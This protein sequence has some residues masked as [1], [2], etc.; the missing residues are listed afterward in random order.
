WGGGDATRRRL[1]P[2]GEQLE[3][4]GRGER[5][6]ELVRRGD[7]DEAVGRGGDDLLA[8][9]RRAAALD[10]PAVRRDLV[11]AVDRDVETVERVERLDRQ[12]EPARRLLRPERRGDAADPQVPRRESRE[13]EPDRRAGAETDGHSVLD[14]LGRGLRRR[15]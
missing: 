11:G 13:E 2:E 10:E 15:T 14:E 9:V 7:D 4:H 6:D 8:R 1:E 5:L 12:T 3:R